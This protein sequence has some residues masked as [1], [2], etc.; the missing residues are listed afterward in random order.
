VCRP[1]PIS[2]GSG[3]VPYV[4]NLGA[5]VVVV[6]AGSSGAVVAGRLAAAGVDVMLIEAG[7]DY[8]PLVAGN[9]PAELLDAS[10]LA[11]THDWGYR[12]GERWVFER[13]RVLGGCST[14]NGAIAAV[15]HRN[16]YDAWNLDGWTTDEL[17]PLFGTALAKMRVR[18][19]TPDEAGPFHARCLDAARSA[20]WFVASDLC[21]LD[22]GTSFGLETVNVVDGVRWNTGLAYIDPVRSSPQL[23]ILDRAIVDRVA[24]GSDGVTVHV[25]RD[26]QPDAVSGALVVLA[27]GVYGTPTILERSG[28]GDPDHL[29]R[30][31]V[32]PVASSPLVGSNLHD[33]P[34]INA[35]RMLSEDLRRS[36]ELAAAAG[37][38]PEEQTLGKACSSLADGVFD[39]HLFPVCASTQTTLTHGRALVEV[40]CMTPRSRGAVHISSTD[41]EGHP[42]ID[43]CYLSD[44]DD[45]DVTVLADGLVLAEELLSQ[46]ALAEVLIP[47]PPR[48]RDRAAIRRDVQHYYH[49]VGTARMGLDPAT[50]VCDPRGKVHGVERIVVADVS[51]MPQIPRANTNIPAVMI[52]ERISTFLLA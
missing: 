32:T 51:L 7:P 28:I 4:S 37:F 35:G 3:T 8:G 31:G 52:G 17:R 16:D 39:L 43:H 26:G 29:R 30:V 22:A 6:G 25:I 24:V 14:H 18:A 33:H 27:A 38:V 47:E 5:D 20:G 44:P 11:T 10:A 21:D 9:W 23:T 48:S 13:A 34:L 45:H 49:P 42:S 36:I 41:P 46:P 19:Y 15:G 1:R 12:S 40:A 50:S 2:F